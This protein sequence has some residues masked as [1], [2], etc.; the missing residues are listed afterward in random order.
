[1][2]KCEV[3][4]TEVSDMMVHMKEQVEA[5]DAAHKVASDKWMAENPNATA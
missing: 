3:C 2:K 1:M 4:G 5:G